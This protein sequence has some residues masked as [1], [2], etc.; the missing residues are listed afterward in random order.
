MSMAI[1]FEPGI[2]VVRNQII[3]VLQLL[4]SWDVFAPGHILKIID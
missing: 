2:Q 3:L 1:P 4:T